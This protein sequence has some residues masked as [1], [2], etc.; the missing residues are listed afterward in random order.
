MGKGKRQLVSKGEAPEH[1][2]PLLTGTTT[3]GSP[4][5]WNRR[6]AQGWEQSL[7][8]LRV[9]THEMASPELCSS[10]TVSDSL[11]ST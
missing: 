11:E 4:G 3:H 7:P 8:P 5:L 6:A 9:C 2:E 1:P 10:A